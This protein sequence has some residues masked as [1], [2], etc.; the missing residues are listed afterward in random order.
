MTRRQLIYGVVV[1]GLAVSLPS[2]PA[3][4]LAFGLG[5]RLWLDGRPCG[6]IIR[7][8]HAVGVHP[9]LP[10]NLK[11]TG[12]SLPG[13]DTRHFCH[14]CRPVRVFNRSVPDR[15][16]RPYGVRV[17]HATGPFPG[18]LSVP[19]GVGKSWG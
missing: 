4:T 16:V 9:M 1:A 8:D 19:V 14:G 18:S 17:H 3:H 5:H 12:T 15:L 10:A 2:L 11:V 6:G 13:F 7:S